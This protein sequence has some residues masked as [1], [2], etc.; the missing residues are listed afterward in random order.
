MVLYG[1]A[2]EH[3]VLYRVAFCHVA[4]CCLVVRNLVRYHVPCAV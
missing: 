4:V 1:R 2:L 3:V